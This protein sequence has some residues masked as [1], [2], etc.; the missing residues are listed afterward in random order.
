[1]WGQLDRWASYV[2]CLYW[3][4]QRVTSSASR[5]PASARLHRRDE[6]NVTEWY[7][8]SCWTR[9]HP[10]LL[11]SVRL[12]ILYNH[13]TVVLW[14]RERPSGLWVFYM[15]MVS[16]CLLHVSGEE[17][18][19]QRRRRNQIYCRWICSH[20]LITSNE[21]LYSVQWY[22][23]T[24]PPITWDRFDTNILLMSLSDS[25]SSLTFAMFL[26]FTCVIVL[27]IEQK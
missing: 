10:G 6:I 9:Q 14:A 11:K 17:S 23:Q 2:L 24:T 26:T 8:L 16:G 7:E 18:V 1:M 15:E 22:W 5:G 3:S 21:L 25:T 4:P 20:T 12:Y 27:P 19:N 13:K